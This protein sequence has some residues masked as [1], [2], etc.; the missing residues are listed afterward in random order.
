[1]KKFYAYQTQE[2]RNRNLHMDTGNTVLELRAYS[3]TVN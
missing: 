3:G 1:M 2:N